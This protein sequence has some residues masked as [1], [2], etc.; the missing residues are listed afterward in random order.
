MALV[1]NLLTNITTKNLIDF[2]K[3]YVIIIPKAFNLLQEGHIW[4]KNLSHYLRLGK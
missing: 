1:F 3:S 2:I 4:I